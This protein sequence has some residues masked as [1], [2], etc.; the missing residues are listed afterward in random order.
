MAQDAVLAAV[1]HQFPHGEEV[2]CVLQLGDEI[3]FLVH[4]GLHIGGNFG[5]V[6]LTGSIVGEF[7]QPLTRRV[8]LGNSL[9][10]VQIADFVHGE[11]TRGS[12][13]GAPFHPP[14]IVG[15]EGRDLSSRLETEL[16]IGFEGGSGLGKLEAK[17]NAGEHILKFL[18]VAVVIEHF[19]GSDGCQTK[20][21]GPA[22]G[23]CFKGP[24]GGPAVTCH[25]G[26]QVATKRLGKQAQRGAVVAA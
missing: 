25:H 15:K 9:L 14:G 11:P 24:V 26:R 19:R 17:P 2:T 3:E 20:A 10:R 21:C 22:Q 12:H 8:P 6:A 4:L 18:P 5:P 1:L 16:R 7:A 23:V 13:F